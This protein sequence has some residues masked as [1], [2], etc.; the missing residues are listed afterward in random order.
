MILAGSRYITNKNLHLSG[1]IHFNKPYSRSFEFELPEGT[2]VIVSIWQEAY[3]EFIQAFLKTPETYEA[4]I[5]GEE[6]LNSPYYDSYSFLI[7]REIF[8]MSCND[9]TNFSEAIYFYSP[10]EENGYLSNFSSHGIEIKDVYYPTVEHYFQSQKFED[11]VYQRKII[12][13]ESPKKASELG[14]TRKINIRKD[15]EEIKNTLMKKA[16]RRKFETHRSIKD[17]LID[18]ADR[19]LI[20]NSPYDNY[21]GIGSSGN[22]LNQLGTILMQ[23][24]QILR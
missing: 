4:S 5:V 11:E 2:E 19:M 9:L 15:W 1:L 24:R 8:S 22:G 14:R 6:F 20:E 18:T 21:W 7:E 12:E 10:N 23:V 3:D 16:V 17:K 13:A